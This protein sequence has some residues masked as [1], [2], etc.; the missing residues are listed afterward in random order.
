MIFFQGLKI[1][2]H[3]SEV[4][5]LDKDGFEYPPESILTG[6]AAYQFLTAWKKNKSENFKTWLD[7]SYND[8]EHGEF[9]LTSEDSKLENPISHLLKIRLNKNRQEL[10]KSRQ[11]LPQYI[12]AGTGEH[13][14]DTKIL[15][16][17]ENETEKFQK[18]MAEFEIE[19]N[20]YF[21]NN[22]EI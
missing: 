3:G 19:E 17:V 8:Y 6:V 1:I 2:Y 16:M 13:I 15:N 10:L 4:E 12:F 9:F 14:S 18:A 21:D 5:I 20:R 22:V 11:N 7:F